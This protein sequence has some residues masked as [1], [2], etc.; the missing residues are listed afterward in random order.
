MN[1][2]S[3]IFALGSANHEDQNPMSNNKRLKILQAT[4]KLLAEE[5]FH[6]ISMQKVAH[7]A[8]VA[9]GTIYRYFSD[10]DDLL[11]EV[12]KMVSQR[13]AD[14]VQAN[15]D[16]EMPLKQRFRVMWL[17]IWHLARTEGRTLCNQLQYESL[18]TPAYMNIRELEREMFAKVDQM[19][20]EGK[21]SGVL[22]PLDNPILSGLSLEVGVT[23]ARKHALGIF[24]L[25]DDALEAAIEAS[26][27]AIVQH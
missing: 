6:G 17:N 1:E 26:W 4:E 20:T 19:F 24:Q 2:R 14:V 13:I 9:A 7:S 21:Q 10:K 18:P 11:I 15:V 16:D 25:D 23:L 22:K 27:D 5:G 3:F 12:R 8:G